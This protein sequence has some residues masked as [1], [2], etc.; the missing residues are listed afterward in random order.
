MLEQEEGS[1]RLPSEPQVCR[2]GGRVKK[3]TA[4]GRATFTLPNGTT[5][6]N[7]PPRPTHDPRRLN[8]AG[9]KQTIRRPTMHPYAVGARLPISAVVRLR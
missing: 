1:S 5:L 9:I 3:C 2:G 8:K 6:T 4:T 7:E